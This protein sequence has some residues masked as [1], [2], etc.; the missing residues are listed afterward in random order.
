[1]SQIQFRKLLQKYLRGQATD[2]DLG[3]IDCWYDTLGKDVESTFDEGE[4]VRLKAQM[5]QQIQLVK[6]AADNQPDF[7]IQPV[8]VSIY[9]ERTGSG[10]FGGLSMRWRGA[11]AALVLLVSGWLVW[12]QAGLTNAP[13]AVARSSVNQPIGLIDYSNDAQQPKLLILSD[14]SRV[15]LNRGGRLQV[16]RSF[17]PH[18]RE[19]FLQGNAFFAVEQNPDKPFFVYAGRSVTRVLGTSFWIKAGK[20]AEQVE[21]AVYTG[22][23]AVS[24]QEPDKPVA[25]KLPENEMNGVVLTPNQRVTFHAEQN[26]FVTNLVAR[27]EVV[28]EEYDAPPP[29]ISF[30]YESALL[31]TVLAQMQQAYGIE[32]LTANSAL[33][34]CMFSGNITGL[35]M[36]TQLEVICR[37]IGADYA[38]RGTR[39]VLSGEGCLGK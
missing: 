27:P 3:L 4:Q 6:T 38:V 2:S 7:P 30:A 37:T 31:S 10:P 16:A 22:R 34:N 13:D 1:M 36:H 26:H 35:P 17:G 19:V 5:W 25:T 14:G 33:N 18:K 15:W 21:V 24:E 20:P 11:V 28:K 12:Q 23:V 32:M 9:R 29:A 39:I 8:P